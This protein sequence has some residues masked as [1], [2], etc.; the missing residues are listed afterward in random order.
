MKNFISP[1]TGITFLFKICL[2]MQRYKDWV[3]YLQLIISA[4]NYFQITYSTK[5][6][7]VLP[8]LAIIFILQVVSAVAQSRADVLGLKHHFGYPTGERTAMNHMRTK[9]YAGSLLRLLLGGRPES[10]RHLL[11]QQQ[12]GVRKRPRILYQNI[13]LLHQP[14]G[15]MGRAKRGYERLL[16]SEVDQLLG[17]ELRM[18]HQLE[19]IEDLLYYYDVLREERGE[20]KRRNAYNYSPQ[21]HSPVYLST[22]ESYTEPLKYHS[23]QN[24]A[25]LHQFQGRKRSEE[26][27][28]I[29]CDT[30]DA[31]GWM[32][33]GV[34]ADD[35]AGFEDSNDIYGYGD[36]SKRTP[37]QGSLLHYMSGKSFNMPNLVRTSPSRKAVGRPVTSSRASGSHR[38]SS[39][40][41]QYNSDLG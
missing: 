35:L 24:V 22:G 25:L 3:C 6:S 2:Q 17:S 29:D 23:Q 28:C 30:D 26:S 20:G 7:P 27:T 32:E 15:F 19:N 11:A 12:Q 36:I 41:Y 31:G 9:R 18:E 37:Y 10:A 33:D 39:S 1:Q 8:V 14:S 16:K 38:T 5:M 4:Y 34:N 13:P 40:V 21:L